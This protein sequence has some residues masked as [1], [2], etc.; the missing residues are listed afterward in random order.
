MNTVDSKDLDIKKPPVYSEIKD[1]FEP[2]RRQGKD[3][4]HYKSRI[5]HVALKA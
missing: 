1:Y 5:K 2:L 3:A 4:Y